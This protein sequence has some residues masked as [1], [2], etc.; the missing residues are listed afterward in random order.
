MAAWP[1]AMGIAPPP[2]GEGTLLQTDR[3]RGIDG[4]ADKEEEKCR[5][6]EIIKFVILSEPTFG[7]ADINNHLNM[8]SLL[9]PVSLG[10]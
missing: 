10:G 8:F 9:L 2:L 3:D 7:V 5:S 1:P 6:R 4:W